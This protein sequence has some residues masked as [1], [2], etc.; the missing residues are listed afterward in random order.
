MKSYLIGVLTAIQMFASGANIH[1]QTAAVNLKGAWQTEGGAVYAT[2][3]CSEK[4]FAV[5]IYDQTSKK[6]IGT[7][8][9]SYRIDKNVFVAAIEFHSMNAELIG[10]ELRSN[11]EWKKGFFAVDDG[12]E[13]V[14]WTQID[15]GSPGQLSGTWI[16]TGRIREGQMVKLNP[17]A[18]KT[19][20]LLSGTR[21]QWIAFNVQTKEFSGT[22]GGT[23]TTKAGKYTENIE[24]FSRDP[25]RAGKSLTFDFSI[26]DGDW[27][28]K[29]T[30]SKGEAIEEVWTKREKTGL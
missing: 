3:I 25:S 4:Y 6:F 21:F 20:K 15:D 8:R 5:A 29:G 30:S 26:E 27:R 9:G 1:G 11:F 2:M 12:S 22:G 7:H 16:I 24:F 14:R 18:R 17:G 19:L 23:Y 28:H 10:K 13:K